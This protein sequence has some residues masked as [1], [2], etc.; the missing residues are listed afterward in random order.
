MLLILKHWRVDHTVIRGAKDF[1][2][3]T[4][5]GKRVGCSKSSTPEAHVVCEPLGERVAWLLLTKD[6][7]RLLPSDLH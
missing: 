2:Y 3:G 7:L 5:F 6:L 1:S 4:A